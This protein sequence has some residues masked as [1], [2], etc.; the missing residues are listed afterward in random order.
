MKKTL[1][2]ALAVVTLMLSA[3]T[4]SVMIEATTTDSIGK[5]GAV[6][7]AETADAAVYAKC[8]AGML[9]WRVIHINWL[10]R[11]ASGRCTGPLAGA[12]NRV[13]F[14]CTDSKMR[15]RIAV[16]GPWKPKGEMS[17][18]TCPK[19]LTYGKYLWYIETVGGIYSTRPDGVWTETRG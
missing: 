9:S 8:P 18:A 14:Y 11:K 3:V 1:W 7:R 12:E 15:T 4:V 13:G 17:T 16:Y 5:H 6:F 19:A 2:G 10:P